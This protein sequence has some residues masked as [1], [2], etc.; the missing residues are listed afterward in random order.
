MSAAS[1]EAQ[2]RTR[3][4]ATRSKQTLQAL[5]HGAL[6][7]NESMWLN[8]SMLHTAP[9]VPL[10]GGLTKASTSDGSVDFDSAQSNLP[11]LSGT[12]SPS[13]T[14]A[15]SFKGNQMS[16]GANQTTFGADKQESQDSQA[17]TSPVGSAGPLFAM[18][19]PRQSWVDTQQL[20]MCEQQ[21]PDAAFEMGPRQSW[22]DTQQLDAHKQQQDARKQQLPDAAFAMGPR[23]SW[24]DTQQL[25]SLLDAARSQ[26]A[27]ADAARHADAPS[28]AAARQAPAA[29]FTRRVE[30]ATRRVEEA[31]RRVDVSPK[32]AARQAPAADSTRR[33]DV[34]SK[35]AA[36]QAP[37]PA[38]VSSSPSG[39]SA[40]TRQPIDRLHTSA[41]LAPPSRRTARYQC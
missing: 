32:A 17:S 11:G 34:S 2:Q 9:R 40:S 14:G 23:Q 36:R 28:K 8:E 31:A 38:L 6:L 41:G 22:A 35:S 21:L 5:A 16:F 33:A 37:A 4:G 18:G 15:H 20:D 10:S 3:D 1:F 29:D 39:N 26:A 30:D 24:A 7:L 27:A 25:D 19:G 12:V 13:E